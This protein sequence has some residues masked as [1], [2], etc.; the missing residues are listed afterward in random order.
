M[1]QLLKTL[2]SS[3]IL[4][5]MD[6]LAI[7]AAFA[8]AV[9]IRNWI[10]TFVELPELTTNDFMFYVTS[11]WWILPLYLVIFTSKGLYTK[12]RPFWQETKSIITS[13]SLAALL[14][15][16]IVSLGKI[17]LYFSRVL[18]VLHP[19]ILA[20]LIPLIRRIVKALLYKIHYWEREVIEVRVDSDQSL[21][22]SFSRNSFIGYRVK[23]IVQ[24]SLGKD[25]IVAIVERAK[26]ALQK[27]TADTILVVVKDFASPQI[28]ELVERLYFV[29]N[30]ILVVPELMD[31]DV[32]NAD[33]YHLMYE[34]LFVFD[35][36]KG[37]NNP[38]NQ[39][40][41]RTLDITLST[42]GII[43]ATPILLFEAILVLVTDGFPI[44][45]DQE[46]YGKNGQ[47]FT[48]YKFRTMRK[49]AYK[50]ENDDILW[51]YLADHPE[52]KKFWDKYQK[53][54]ND[55]R[56]I[57]GMNIIRRTSIDEIAQL[58][59]V[60]KGD[61]S[62]VGPR[63]FLPREKEL[64]KDYSDRILAAKP[65]V[66]DLWTVSGRDALAFDK[67]L[68]MGTW[69]IQNWSLWLDLVIIAKTVQ[70]VILYFF[71]WFKKSKK[72]STNT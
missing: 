17:D 23:G 16:S 44:F 13:I 19:L 5:A 52:E 8:V 53:L 3:L 49:E 67:R 33:V 57:K 54:E 6:V 45:Y 47:I 60:L 10:G 43:F 40:I 35:I 7:V 62:M 46:R 1:K 69:Y 41:K 65:G 63:P 11:N 12:H 4:A 48:F 26:K 36:D 25:G 18:F 31:L 27:T 2:V 70:Q 42:I 29:S 24:A 22:S 55:P 34:N 39:V 64:M 59:N 14:V 58:F 71:K 21:I 56:I 37:L 61:M 32:L 51:K 30:H 9:W 28:A 68:K 38:L 20:V 72:A 50:D 66:T 15:Y